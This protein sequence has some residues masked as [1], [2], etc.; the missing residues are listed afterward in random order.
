M[1]TDPLFSDPDFYSVVLVCL[2]MTYCLILSRRMA[3]FMRAGGYTTG[4]VTGEVARKRIDPRGGVA[5]PVAV[6]AMTLRAVLVV[7]L[8]AGCPLLLA[9]KV[10]AEE[11][12]R[13]DEK[14]RDRRERPHQW[15]STSA[16]GR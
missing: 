8:L 15:C 11:Q 9:A 16:R 3:T 13:R 12:R 4:F 5:V 2:S 14:D 1:F 7:Q 6:D 10:A